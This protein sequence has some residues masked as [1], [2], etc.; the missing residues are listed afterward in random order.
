MIIYPSP[1]APGFQ[2]IMTEHADI[3]EEWYQTSIVEKWRGGLAL[4]PK[5][6]PREEGSE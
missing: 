1:A 4:V 6:W 2:I 3:N 5:D